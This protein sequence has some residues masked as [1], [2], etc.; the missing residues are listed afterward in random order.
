MASLP[1][2]RTAGRASGAGSRVHAFLPAFFA[3]LSA[4]R[5]RLRWRAGKSRRRAVCRSHA[6][7]ETCARAHSALILRS[8]AAPARSAARTRLGCAAMRLEEP[9]PAQAGDEGGLDRCGPR[10]HMVR[11]A[12]GWVDPGLDPGETQ[13]S[14]A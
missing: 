5:L 13:H 7:G 2:M 10:G 1:G 3:G 9:A 12:V 8:I 11:D 6:R 14:V 4:A